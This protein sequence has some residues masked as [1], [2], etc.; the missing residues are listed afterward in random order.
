MNGMTND[1]PPLAPPLPEIGPSWWEQNGAIAVAGI[2]VLLAAAGLLLWWWLR[3]KPAPVVPP[4]VA[5]RRHLT[6]LAELAEDGAVLSQVTQ[7]LRRY[8]TAA[9]GLAPGELTTAELRAALRSDARIGTELAGALC[10]FLQDCDARKFS[11]PPGTGPAGATQ[12][13][14]ELVD[15]IHARTSN[16]SAA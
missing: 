12:R 6:A 8:A 1:I 10:Q 13:A 5:A 7:T 15:A 11:P 9:A 14:L 16:R 2:A 4:D 3:P